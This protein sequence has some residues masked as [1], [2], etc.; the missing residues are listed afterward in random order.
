MKTFRNCAVA[1]LCALCL[2]SAGCGH[3]TIAPK[4]VATR[5][6]SSW[7]RHNILSANDKGILVTAEFVRV[8]H[9][10]L[11]A[12]GDKLSVS[13]RPSSPT[14][15]ITPEGSNFRISYEV[16]SRFA[17]LKYFERNAS[18]P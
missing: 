3:L 11:T 6:V 14:D 18:S 12:Y 7:A 15:G 10:L 2:L 13:S 9:A 8:Y 4:P 16:Q 17:D 1:Y 5:Q